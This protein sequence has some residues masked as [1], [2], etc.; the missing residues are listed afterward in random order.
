MLARMPRIPTIKKAPARA[1]KSFP[2]GDDVE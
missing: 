2:R 1:I